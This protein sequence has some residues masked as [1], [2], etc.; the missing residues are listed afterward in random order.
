MVHACS[1]VCLVPVTS[2]NFGLK[3]SS[4]YGKKWWNTLGEPFLLRHPVVLFTRQLVALLC[5][6]P[7]IMKC[8]CHLL[9]DMVCVG[10]I[11]RWCSC[12]IHLSEYLQVLP[13]TIRTLLILIRIRFPLNE[14][15]FSVISTALLWLQQKTCDCG[16]TAALTVVPT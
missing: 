13:W 2:S 12:T 3:I 9:N 8:L 1:S 6:W 7:V 5:H 4:D 11:N 10:S 14:S 16:C 15:F